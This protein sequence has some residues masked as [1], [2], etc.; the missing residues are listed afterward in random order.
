MKNV[1]LVFI[2]LLAGC[3]STTS[4]SSPVFSDPM[5]IIKAAADS[6]P[7]GVPGQ[8]TLQIVATGSQGR[9]VYLNTEDDY[10]D[11]RAIT[12]ALHPKI[13]AQLSA[14]YGM[15]PQEYFVNKAI[16]VDGEAQRVKIVFISDGKPTNKYYYQTHIRLMDISQ[17][18]VVGENTQQTL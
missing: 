7:K 11:Q 16:V 8:Y 10:R 17:L 13:I 3:A 2:L 15:S 4:T 12:V 5:Q 6:A 1:A 14:K 18:E 9:Y